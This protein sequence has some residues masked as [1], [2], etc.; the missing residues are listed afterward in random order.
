MVVYGKNWSNFYFNGVFGPKA[1]NWEKFSIL[2]VTVLF[3]GEN[4]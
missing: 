2:F 3:M 4:G 1:N